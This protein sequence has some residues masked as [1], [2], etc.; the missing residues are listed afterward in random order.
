MTWHEWFAKLE[1]K[2]FVPSELSRFWNRIGGPATPP[3]NLWGNVVPTLLLLDALRSHLNTPIRINSAYRD[4][5][6]N[7]KV[8]GAK[9]SQHMD[10]AAIDFTCDGVAPEEVGGILV[11]MR[12]MTLRS[13]IVIPDRTTCDRDIPREELA[14]WDRRRDVEGDSVFAWIGGIGVYSTFV[15]VDSR[16]YPATWQG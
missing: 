15:H 9:L 3:R 12:G 5:F 2:H 14:I 16:G 13:P 10:F 4:P 8:G 11:G 1:L 6:Y 7:E